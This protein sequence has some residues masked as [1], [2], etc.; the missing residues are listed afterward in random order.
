MSW[1]TKNGIKALLAS[2]KTLGEGG[3]CLLWPEN[4]R[5]GQKNKSFWSV[6]GCKP[7]ILR[8]MTWLRREVF[9]DEG[10]EENQRIYIAWSNV[11]FHW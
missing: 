7:T 6:K 2:H 4:D 11:R 5:N 9:S 1:I 3:Q 8:I 10:D